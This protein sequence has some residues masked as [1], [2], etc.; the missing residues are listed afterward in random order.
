MVLRR[1]FTQ[2]ELQLEILAL[3]GPY[4]VLQSPDGKEHV[5]FAEAEIIL[6]QVKPMETAATGIDHGIVGLQMSGHHA[7]RAVQNCRM[8]GGIFR[9]QHPGPYQIAGQLGMQPQCQRRIG[10]DVE[11]EIGEIHVEGGDAGVELEAQP[12]QGSAPRRLGEFQAMD[13]HRVELHF[14]GGAEAADHVI[15]THGLGK[16]DGPAR[17]DLGLLDLTDAGREGHDGG[18]RIIP[19]KVGP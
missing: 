14:A 12:D 8:H 6:Q 1:Q 11:L 9:E 4:H 7:A 10:V 5:F 15:L 19:Q 3:R 17:Q 13:P 16:H 2:V 18:G